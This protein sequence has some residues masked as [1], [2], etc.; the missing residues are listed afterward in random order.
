MFKRFH[1]G[2]LFIRVALLLKRHA[3]IAGLSYFN[4]IHT[5]FL[6][7]ASFLIILPHSSRFIPNIKRSDEDF[8]ASS[9][10]EKIQQAIL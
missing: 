6:I 3:P 8:H 10:S 5:S 1:C 4:R 2:P 9:L 7:R